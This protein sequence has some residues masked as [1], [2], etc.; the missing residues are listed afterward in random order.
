MK[1]LYCLS[2][3]LLGA[4][5]LALYPA[6]AQA[7]IVPVANPSFEAPLTPNPPGWFNGDPAGWT[8][9]GDNGGLLDDTLAGIPPIPDGEQV[10]WLDSRG[11]G[12]A[13]YTKLA[14]TLW[15]A[16]WTLSV[17]VGDRTNLPLPSYN[18]GFYEDTDADNVPD[19]P[20]A[21]ATDPVTPDGTFL[22]TSLTAQD[23]P[24]GTSLYLQFD[25]PG[26]TSDA[27]QALFDVVR[28]QAVVP[29]PATLLIWSLLAGLGLVAGWWRRKR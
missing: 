24:A 22:Q 20:V 23:V 21:V 16:D 2:L 19:S 28:V 8:K 17:Y 5:T 9:V 14:D 10:A 12:A 3:V 15:P 29:E 11:A 18:I 26:T 27:R 7:V 13:I 1:R 6:A 25:V 4:A